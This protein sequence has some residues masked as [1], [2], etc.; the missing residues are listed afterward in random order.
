MHGGI[1]SHYWSIR[2]H[3][4]AQERICQVDLETSSLHLSFFGTHLIHPRQSKKQQYDDVSAWICFLEHAETTEGR[5]SVLG[6]LQPSSA[7]RGRVATC[8]GNRGFITKDSSPQ[9]VFLGWDEKKKK[10]FPNPYDKTETHT[11]VLTLLCLRRHLADTWGNIKPRLSIVL[12]FFFFFSS[13]ALCFPQ[14]WK[15]EYLLPPSC[16]PCSLGLIVPL[17]AMDSHTGF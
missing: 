17:C 12:V 8:L 1:K 4:I 3:H 16:S 5:Q 7:V 11:A 15:S 9:S 2:F 14:S 6:A 13:P 10:H